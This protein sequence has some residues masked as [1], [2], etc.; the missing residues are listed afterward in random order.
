MSVTDAARIPRGCDCGVR[1]LAAAALIRLLAWELAYAAGVALKE[2][3]KVLHLPGD[4]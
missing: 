3:K 2:K 1:R 4:I